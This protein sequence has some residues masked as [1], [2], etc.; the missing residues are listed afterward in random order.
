[1]VASL[2]PLKRARYIVEPLMTINLTKDSLNLIS[3]HGIS[4]HIYWTISSHVG[5]NYGTIFH[6]SQQASNMVLKQMMLRDHVSHWNR[7][8][9]VILPILKH[10]HIGQWVYIYN[11]IYTHDIPMNVPDLNSWSLY[12]LY[13]LST[14][15]HTT[16]L[17]GR[18]PEVT[19]REDHLGG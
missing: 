16:N 17:C 10:T 9:I 7:F 12:Q 18:F 5:R 2:I 6:W 8:I 19:S 11:Y 1:M 13:D 15:T 4:Q 3:T 14:H